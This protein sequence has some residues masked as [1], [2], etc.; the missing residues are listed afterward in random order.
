MRAS[1]RAIGVVVVFAAASGGGTA[2]KVTHPPAAA[3]PPAAPRTDT[4]VTGSSETAYLT[5]VLKNLGDPVN[6]QNLTSLADWVKRE[7]TWPPVAKYNPL[8]TTQQEPGATEFNT[9]TLS[10]GQVIHVW[11]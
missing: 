2:A 9:I 10:N 1:T 5:A 3:P 6:G 11:N 7:T 4:P 8:N